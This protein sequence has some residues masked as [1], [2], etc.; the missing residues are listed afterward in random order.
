MSA[1]V[2]ESSSFSYQLCYSSK[3]RSVALQIKHGELTVRAPSG[4]SLS[5]IQ[6]LV[7][8]KQSWILKHLQLDAQQ[9]K[10]DWLA[11]RQLPLLG[12]MLTLELRRAAKSSVNLYNDTLIVTVSS[13]T[14]PNGYERRVLSLLQQWYKTEASNWFTARL[15]YWQ[16]QMQLRA[17]AVVIGNWQ[18]KWGYCKNST[19]LGFNWRL[20][21]APAWV[22]DYVVV[23][24]LAHIKHLDHSARFWL[25]VEQHYPLAAQAKL[26][27]R[28]NQY[29]M[30][31]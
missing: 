30:A 22:A 25:L 19:E 26:W 6:K 13:R 12:A 23:H 9:V 21:M 1:Q 4:C 7:D 3:R 11:S 27:L 5:D 17:A 2:I 29:Q 14:Q 24:E 8:K 15:S 16:T 10:P 18:T 28:Q 31:I 20:M